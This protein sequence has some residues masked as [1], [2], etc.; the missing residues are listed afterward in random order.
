MTG[1]I[2][3]AAG[4]ARRGAGGDT[5]VTGGGGATVVVGAGGGVDGSVAGAGAAER[6]T[7]PVPLSTSWGSP[8]WRKRRVRVFRRRILPATRGE[9]QCSCCRD[10]GGGA[11]TASVLVMSKQCGMLNY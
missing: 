8:R 7:T 4:A 1:P 2:P 11:V 6:G 3:P 9:K 10:G 5:V